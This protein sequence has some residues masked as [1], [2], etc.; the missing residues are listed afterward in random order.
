MRACDGDGERLRS[1]GDDERAERLA[2]VVTGGSDVYAEARLAAGN[3][4]SGAATGSLMERRRTRVS[5][6]GLARRQSCKQL[7]TLVGSSR[8]CVCDLAGPG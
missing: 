3:N 1:C 5:Q 6:A 4:R 2:D 7:R 8:A